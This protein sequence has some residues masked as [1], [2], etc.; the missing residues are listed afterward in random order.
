MRDFNTPSQDAG[1]S[2]QPVPGSSGLLCNAPV[3]CE[4]PPP[5]THARSCA[6]MLGWLMGAGLFGGG[7][8]SFRVPSLQPFCPDRGG[9]TI[10][11]SA[12]SSRLRRYRTA[13]GV[14]DCACEKRSCQNSGWVN[15]GVFGGVLLEVSCHGYVVHHLIPFPPTQRLS[16]LLRHGL[17]RDKQ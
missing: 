12:T 8:A 13:T 5:P 11:T 4:Q 6:R 10:A 2:Q 3:A 15:K 14:E 7:H 1:R 9:E 17:M 16:Q